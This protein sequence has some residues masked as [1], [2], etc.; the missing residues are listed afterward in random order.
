MRDALIFLLLVAVVVL[1]VMVHGQRGV[2]AVQEKQIKELS[3]KLESKQVSLD[4]QQQCAVQARKE[5]EVDGWSGKDHPLAAFVNH[6]NAKLGRCFMSVE[7]TTQPD[8]R[9]STFFTNKFVSDAFEG[10]S[11]A[12][13]EWK[14][15]K[16]KKYWEVKPFQCEVTLPSGEKKN[17]E[18]SDEFDELVKVYLE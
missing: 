8:K 11:Y 6:Y 16:G 13:Y 12:Q 2:L 10:K 9:E 18:S 17:C 15:E 14:S 4:L 5:F 1:G 3:S 7:D